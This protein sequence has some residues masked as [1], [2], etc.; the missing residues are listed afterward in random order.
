[1]DFPYKK[2]VQ[3]LYLNVQGKIS[4][5]VDTRLSGIFTIYIVGD[6][7]TV[8]LSVLVL[9]GNAHQV[10]ARISVVAG[11]WISVP[12]VVC[13]ADPI[14]PVCGFPQDD[15]IP[16]RDRWKSS[17]PLPDPLVLAP[18]KRFTSGITNAGTI[19]LFSLVYHICW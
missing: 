3:I 5:G 1:M 7:K 17:W 12:G 9:P 15:R 10:V 18:G 6:T 4:Q 11:K 16:I 13:C 14:L 8:D 2:A 19:D